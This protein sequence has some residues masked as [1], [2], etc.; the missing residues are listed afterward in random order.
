MG[1]ITDRQVA[2]L[3]LL[4]VSLSSVSTGVRAASLPDLTIDNIWLV[5]AS[6]PG[7]NVTQPMAGDQF[8]IAASVKNIGNAPAFGYYVDVY[9]DG[10][11]GRSGPDNITS[12]G[13]QVWYVGPITAEAGSHTTTWVVNPNNTITELNYDNNVKAYTFSVP[14]CS[15]APANI[16]DV[17][18][19][20][21]SASGTSTYFIGTSN[22][23]D[24]QALLGAW[25]IR[26]GQLNSTQIGP[27]TRPDWVNQ[28]TGQPL[29][30]GGLVLVAGPAANPVVNYY[31]S[32]G[33]ALGFRFFNGYAQIV[34]RSNVLAQMPEGDIGKGKDMFVVQ[35]FEDGGRPVLAIWGIGA[36]GTLASGVWLVSSFS[37][38][39]S[40][41]HSTYIYTWTDSNG[42]NYPQPN[43]FSLVYV[44]D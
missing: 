23:Y 43:E 4:L 34:Y 12:G 7:Q 25:G 44:G 10:Y 26:A 36:Q 27:W 30:A 2:L 5:S 24:N 14:C 42:D 40:L 35:A 8:D 21:F 37:N 17:S 18:P 32:Q 41:N 9:Y 1:T 16:S 22:P 19:L 15:L 33:L 11:F 28:A 39:G 31:V 20:V 3:L 38:L 29:F 6:N 13:V